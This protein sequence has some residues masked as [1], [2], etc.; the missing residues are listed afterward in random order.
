MGQMAL[1][2]KTGLGERLISTSSTASETPFQSLPIIDLTDINSPDLE[3][4][5]ALAAAVQK[6]C[7]VGGKMVVHVLRYA[8]HELTERWSRWLGGY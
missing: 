3:V 1:S 2:L 4:R 8:G 7:Q 5:K 6:V